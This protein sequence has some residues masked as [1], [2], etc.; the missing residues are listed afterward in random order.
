MSLIAYLLTR[1]IIPQFKI[2][3][4]EI[5]NITFT[6]QAMVLPISFIAIAL[7]YWQQKEG[8]KAFFRLGM[9]LSKDDSWNVNGPLIAVLFTVGSVSLMGIG[10]SAEGGTMNETFLMLLPW[11]LLFSATNAW[12]EE[13]FARFVI[14][15]GLTGKLKTS[16]ICLI[17]AII[18]GIPHFFGTPSGIFGVIMSGF[19]GWLLAKS[20]IETRGL[21][22]ALVIHFLQDVIIFGAGA[23]ILAGQ[24]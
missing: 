8:F 22:W 23:M 20:V 12:S 19:L 5:L 9:T 13:I 17:S 16:A 3:Q 15:A 2:S 10:V 1:G 24:Q 11:V 18:F 21:G 4:H 6:M 7:L 14:V